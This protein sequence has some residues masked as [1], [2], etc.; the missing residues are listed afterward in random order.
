MNFIYM[1]TQ[2][3]RWWPLA[4][5]LLAGLALRIA[6][7]GRLPR[8]GL[9]GDE[10]EYLAAADWLALG[11]GF[12]WHQGWLWTRA[13]L[14]PL[15]LAAHIR[16]FGFTTTP[17]VVSQIL[18]SLLVVVLTYA[19]ALRITGRWSACGAALLTA[20]YLPFATY[21]QLLLSETLF[22]ALLLGAFVVLG[23]YA[24][25]AYTHQT[26]GCCSKPSFALRFFASEVGKKPQSK[27]ILRVPSAPAA[28]TT[29]EVALTI[30][31]GLLG[32]A[33]LTRGLALGFIPVVVFW[34]FICGA[35]GW[36]RRLRDALILL[37]TAGAVIVPWAI[38]ATRAYGGL[39]VVDTTGAFNLLYGAR[40]AF[41]GERSDAPTRRFVLALLDPRLSQAERN[42]LVNDPF[43]PTCLLTTNDQALPNAL[44]TP[45]TQISQAQRQQ[46]MS[47]EALCLMR[48]RPLAF[49]QKSL[50]E[51]IDLF[52]INY[53]GD[54]RL[55]DGFTLG[56]LPTWYALALFFLDDTLY[57]LALPLGLLGW[58]LVRS[59]RRAESGEH[60]RKAESGER[61]AESGERKI[62]PNLKPLR[63]CAFASKRD[64]HQ[65]TLG[66]IATLIGLWWLY[67]LATAPLLFAINRFRLPLLPLLFI[68]A[69]FA[70]TNL[71]RLGAVFRHRYGR[72]VA[73]LALLI[74]LLAASP[75]AYLEPRGTGD[76]QWASYLGPYPSS[77]AATWMALTQ[78]PAYEREQTLVRALGQGDTPT[79]Q[80]ILAAGGLQPQVRQLGAVVVAG[81]EGR[82]A[83]GLS[84]LDAPDLLLPPWQRAI[85]R[86]DLLRRAGQT[87]AARAA[88]T[89]TSVDDRNPVQWA[90]EHLDPPPLPDGRIDLGGN[91]DL[92]YIQGFY[93]G[94]GD[95]SAGGNFRWSSAE[96]HLRFP[97]AGG[98]TTI[99][100]RSDGRGWPTDL[101]TPRL[102]LELANQPFAAFQ[103]QRAIETLCAPLPPTQAGSDLTITLRTNAF[104]PNAADLL[105]QQGPQVG[106]LRRLGV[107]LDWVV[108]E[109]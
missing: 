54:E 32:L 99:C 72:G 52:R 95:P 45:V 28:P 47:A 98:A 46:L 76:S 23:R 61:R 68:F 5:A 84:L 20:L 97:Q 7:W 57:V 11:R 2:A 42:A 55:S 9:I 36:K 4:P 34:V 85:L 69:A 26:K 31:G 82:I 15:L 48:T 62:A 18:L 44:A 6:L 21:T 104:T 12:A 25:D 10:A 83:A 105:G 63:L 29:S 16:L 88:F 59:E 1:K 39:V 17:I 65:E 109:H 103:P 75:H 50:T 51:F 92:G 79:A 89:A 53:G 78:R 3:Q 80:A 8:L 102:T 13:P 56:R 64:K 37:I 93:L 27:A 91:L 58:A 40:T 86:G 101:A 90:W 73:T 108:V 49:V 94:E 107:R 41:D 24:A 14:Y 22:L 96:A 100:L 30:G 87:D 77:L 19:L 74:T 71:P 43:H 60:E 81:L 106:Q 70:V 38:Y 66:S 33:T 67:N 35:G